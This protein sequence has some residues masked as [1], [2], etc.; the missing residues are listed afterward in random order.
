MEI[1]KNIKHMRERFKME[2]QELADRL[3]I[4]NKTVSSWE[5]GRTEPRMGMIEAM[6][7]VFGCTKT[8]LIDGE[9]PAEDFTPNHVLLYAQ[10][11]SELPEEQR[12]EVMNFIDYLKTKERPSPSHGMNEGD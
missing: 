4:S 7:E 12:D 3:N 10:I 11:L 5:C 1:G 6:C 2:Q 8:E 9:T